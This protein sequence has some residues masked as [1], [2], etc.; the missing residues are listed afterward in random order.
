MRT[1]RHLFIRTAL[2]AAALLAV[3]FVSIRADEPPR[4]VLISIDGL[5]PSQYLTDGPAKIPTLRRLMSAGIHADG[6]VGV[7]PSVTY[8]SHTS[9][10]TGVPPAVHGIV[11]NRIVDPEGR[12]NGGWFWYA[13]DI[14]VP[15]LAMAARARGLRAGA[16][17]WPA[18][19]GMDLDYVVPEFFR[20]G[21]PES[22]SMLRALSWPRDLIDAAAISRGR[23]FGWPPTD[24]DRAD[25]AIHILRT[26]HPH[27]LLLHLLQHDG[28]Q[29]GFG[30]GS[31]E[32]LE[33]LEQIDGYVADV[34][35]ALQHAGL[36]EQTHVA[37]VSDHGFLA[38]QHLVQPNAAFKR[39]GLIVTSPRGAITSWQAYFHSSGGSGF[40]YLNDPADAV[41]R[42]R[43]FGLLK[44]LQADPANGIRQVWTRAELDTLGAHPEA[45]FGLDVVDGFYTGSG[46]DALVTEST[47]RGGHGFD[48]SRPALHAS[49]LLSGPSV[50]RRGSVGTIRLTQVAP[51][52]AGIL[53]VGLSP[54][55]DEAVVISGTGWGKD[56]E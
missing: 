43:V 36:R 33:A 17:S 1:L 4:L 49:F 9:L 42:D 19:I 12:S 39:E 27:V 28:T 52:L 54:K 30:P 26:H 34:L 56:E 16:V 40:V 10:I 21:H 2:V 29:H 8:P 46:H 55:A 45:A 11:D 37:I 47:T 44:Q 31:P 20:S 25:L 3:V 5:M 51:T 53:G 22:L 7:L 35:D 14:R 13:R 18:T 6:V 38:L 15:T 50:T 41:M 48:P 23:P 24:R 32:S